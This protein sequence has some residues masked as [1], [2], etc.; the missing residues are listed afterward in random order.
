M[1][2]FIDQ[3]QENKI[4]VRRID[5]SKIK[6][7][8]IIFMGGVYDEEGNYLDAIPYI[9]KTKE[10]IEKEKIESKKRIKPYGKIEVDKFSNE[11]EKRK[12]KPLL[13]ADILNME[14]IDEQFLIEKL[15]PQKSLCVLSGYPESGK[16]WIIL[17]LA[18]SVASGTSFLEKYRTQQE[19]VLIVDEETGKQEL[20]R[21]M[22]LLKFDPNLPI[23]FFSQEG[24]KVDNREDL[25]CLLKIVEEKQ[26]KLIIFDPF[27]AIHSK[28]ENEAQEMQKVMESLQKFNLGGA[29]V[30]FAHHHRKQLGWGKTSPSQSLRGSSVLFGRVDSHLVVEKKSEKKEEIVLLI[31][32]EK[33]RKGKKITP[34]QI[35]L[36]ETSNEGLKLKYIGKYEGKKKKIEQ[37]KEVILAV[38]FQEKLTRKETLKKIENIAGQKNLDQAFAQLKRSGK[39]EEVDKKEIIMSN[40]RKRKVPVYAAVKEKRSPEEVA[41]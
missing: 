37:V 29:T 38:L 18:R 3:N 30:I 12:G 22:K 31:T 24:F 39:I 4:V 15:I 8:Q 34:F 20:Q 25:K 28:K 6:D 5:H 11:E 1:A 14:F 2:S 10:E 21:R 33:L 32:Q 7:G 19:N 23:Y 17:E 41:G 9:E 36:T 26:I 16:S 27:V 40:R 35:K 13:V